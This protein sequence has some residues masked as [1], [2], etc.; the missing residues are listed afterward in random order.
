[1]KTLNKIKILLVSAMIA[2][3]QEN[4]DEIV[5]NVHMSGTFS[6]L[7]SF[8]ILPT[9][10]QWQGSEELQGLLL[11]SNPPLTLLGD[12]LLQIMDES[13]GQQSH[14][15][16]VQ[17]RCCQIAPALEYWNSSDQRESLRNLQTFL[18]LNLSPLFRPFERHTPCFPYFLP[19]H[20]C[21]RL[22]LLKEVSRQNFFLLKWG[23]HSRNW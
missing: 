12:T 14:T 20:L 13:H 17:P 22:R 10:S 6:L 1:M 5:T 21:I 8:S 4:G 7:T 2:K 23:N 19:H 16:F 11:Q 9:N 18:S 3:S 15:R